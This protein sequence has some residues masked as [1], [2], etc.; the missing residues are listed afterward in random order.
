VPS[1]VSG[2]G[3]VRIDRA[4]GGHGRVRVGRGVLMGVGVDRSLGCGGGGRRVGGVVLAEGQS[5]DE[6]DGGER[7]AGF[8][9]PR[10]RELT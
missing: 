5:E 3:G 8:P 7:H 9:M 6:G 4:R 1:P 10:P 2:R